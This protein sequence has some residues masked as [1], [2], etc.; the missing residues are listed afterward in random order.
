[1]IVEGFAEAS[2]KTGFMSFDPVYTFQQVLLEADLWN[3]LAL[4]VKFNRPPSLHGVMEENQEKNV[5]QVGI[6]PNDIQPGVN[7]SE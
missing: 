7:R 2:S 3:Q 6:Q 1:M 4:R 5:G